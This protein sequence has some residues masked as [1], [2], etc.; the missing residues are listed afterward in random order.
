[1]VKV[2]LDSAN[3]A[4]IVAH[5]DRIDGCTTN[6]TLMR[7]AGVT[8]YK[9]FAQD[10]IGAIG[11]KPI[12]LEVIADDLDEMRAQAHELASWGKQVFVKIPIVNSKGESTEDVIHGLARSSVKLNITAVMTPKQTELIDSVLTDTPAIV[13]VFA[14]RIA[15]TGRD[16]VRVMRQCADILDRRKNVELLWASVREPLN[17]YQAEDAGVHV[18]TLPPGMLAKLALKDKDLDAF[19]RETAAQFHDDAKAAGYSL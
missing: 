3:I 4:E 9:T 13:S 18:I 15:D 16:P 2:F 11:D 1:M 19:S 6:P 14:G 5:V 7:K 8:D 12:S 10:A 17:Y